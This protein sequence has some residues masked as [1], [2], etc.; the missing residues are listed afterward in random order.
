M[1]N[2]YDRFFESVK[3]FVL[4]THLAHSEDLEGLSQDQIRLIEK[5]YG[6]SLPL[7]FWS[8]L[9]YFGKKSKIINTD[10]YLDFSQKMI[11]NVMQQIEEWELLYS[12]S[13][14]TTIE[15]R[16]DHKNYPMEEVLDLS[17]ILFTQL[18][19]HVDIFI[20]IEC[21]DNNPMV[22]HFEKLYDERKGGFRGYGY[23]PGKLSFVGTFRYFL[24]L[25][26]STKFFRR[27]LVDK[28]SISMSDKDWMTLHDR[29]N[30][31]YVGWSKYYLDK[32][33]KHIWYNIKDEQQRNFY[34]I[35]QEFIKKMDD[36]EIQT[37]IVMTIDEFE[38][39]FL[40]HLRGLGIDI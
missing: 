23:H 35:K 39:A 6:V 1:E 32:D 27:G 9:K 37:G 15:N 25:G 30:L 18:L 40:E 19:E 29:I 7:A 16:L 31:D 36:Q 22:Q 5:R 3:C 8:Y 34:Q 4:E 10:C 33:T 2:R 24:F 11:D 28:D 21:K 38:W 12:V 14:Q 17:T 26:I 20:F 13:E